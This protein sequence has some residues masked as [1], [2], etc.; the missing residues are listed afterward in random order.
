M[1]FIWFDLV[2]R[3]SIGDQCFFGVFVIIQFDPSKSWRLKKKPL[4]FCITIIVKNLLENYGFII[5]I[6]YGTNFFSFS[7]FREKDLELLWRVREPIKA[8]PIKLV[9]IPLS[10]DWVERRADWNTKPDQ[11]SKTKISLYEERTR[12]IESTKSAKIFCLPIPWVQKI[13]PA[14]IVLRQLALPQCYN[15]AT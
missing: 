7:L 1:G 15:L 10:K 14:I 3:G 4:T 8:L 11:V 5:T 6:S 9:K 12:L 13:Y 2:L